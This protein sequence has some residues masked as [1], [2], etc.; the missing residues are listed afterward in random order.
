MSDKDVTKEQKLSI[1]AS[2]I[3]GVKI[4][5]FSAEL[6]II[7][8]NALET[9]E[10][11]IVASANKIISNAGAQIT[12]LEAQYTLIQ[13]EQYIYVDTPKTKN[14]LMI[15]ALQQRIGEL[16]ANYEGQIASLRADLTQ[17]VEIAKITETET[18][19]KET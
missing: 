16:T 9:P 13:A 1:V 15:I 5:K 3:R 10:E 6:N 4:E 19:T 18:E 7:E 11:T 17:L 14:E 8:Q 2:R 12:A